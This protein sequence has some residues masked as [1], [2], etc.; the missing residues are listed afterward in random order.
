MTHN[1][2][3]QSFAR[4]YDIA[5]LFR[6]YR[7]IGFASFQNFYIILL[8]RIITIIEQIISCYWHNIWLILYKCKIF[9]IRFPVMIKFSQNR[10]ISVKRIEQNSSVYKWIAYGKFFCGIFSCIRFS[11]IFFSKSWLALPNGYGIHV[12]S[13]RKI[14]NST[15]KIAP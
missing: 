2:L 7:K 3:Y 4:A 10:L 11:R 1:Q 9:K 6:Q 5:G 8:R 15:P 13:S 12:P 14:V